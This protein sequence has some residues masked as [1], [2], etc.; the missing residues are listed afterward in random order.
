MI[1]RGHRQSYGASALLA[2]TL[3]VG[4]GLAA[5]ANEPVANKLRLEQGRALAD[6]VCS[7][8]H[9]VSD[10]QNNAVADVPTFQEIAD[11]PE[12]TEGRIM[13]RIAIPKHPMPVIPI[14]KE[15]LE[16]VAAY[17]MSLR[18]E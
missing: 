18:S 16:D 6:R 12:Q 15:E 7:N 8:C 14:S 9:L 17:I 10:Q 1:P 13:A 2:V 3:L 4:L 5:Q 11:K